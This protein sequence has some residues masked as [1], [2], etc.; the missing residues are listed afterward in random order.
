MISDYRKSFLLG[1]RENLILCI[2]CMKMKEV[3]H[4]V[5][6]FMVLQVLIRVCCRIDKVADIVEKTRQRPGQR[7][8]SCPDMKI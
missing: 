8:T 4:T 7:S 5:V 6:S 1:T 2:G 3:I